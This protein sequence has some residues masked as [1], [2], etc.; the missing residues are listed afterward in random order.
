[1]N[2]AFDNEAAGRFF[3]RNRHE[4]VASSKILSSEAR[5]TMTAVTTN[6]W[7][8][9]RGSGSKYP[10]PDSSWMM[11]TKSGVPV[12]YDIERRTVHL[13][14]G[15]VLVSDGLYM[16]V[17]SALDNN[18]FV[19]IQRSS[20]DSNNVRAFNASGVQLWQIGKRPAPW[21]N[22]KWEYSEAYNDPNDSM[23]IVVCGAFSARVDPC[24]GRILHVFESW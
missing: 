2:T 10:Q 21:G 6:G 3:A 13:P 5:Y 9:S 17:Q 20:D 4:I 8:V 22:Q 11:V 23:L 14:A 7:T 12:S 15:T 16:V 24:T 18:I 19:V 1:M